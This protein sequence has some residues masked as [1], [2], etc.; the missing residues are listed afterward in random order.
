MTTT[1]QPTTSNPTLG[2]IPAPPRWADTAACASVPDSELFFPLDE[3]SRA[4]TAAKAVCASCQLRARCLEYALAA[5]MA[6]GI[7]G[8]LTTT[9]R[10]ALVRTRRAN[11]RWGA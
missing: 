1:E 4:A 7:W 8:G 5:R 6:A 10:D 3:D 9:Q 2:S 11:A